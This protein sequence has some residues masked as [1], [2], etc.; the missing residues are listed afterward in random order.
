MARSTPT[1]L[2][3][4]EYARHRKARGLP[5]GSREA[6][7]KAVDEGRISTINGLIDP[8]V[9]DIQWEQNTR[10]RVS[11]QAVAT[12]PTPAPTAAPGADLVAQA[13]ADPQAAAAPAAAAADKPAPADNGYTALRARREK[14]DAEIA[15]MNSAKM[16]GA[17]VLRED[18]DRAIFEIGRELRDRLA[19]CARRVA[20]EVSSLATAE[21]CEEVIDREHR[22]VLELLVTSFREKVGAPPRGA[23]A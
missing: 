12:T 6:V 13:A 10:A 16:A 15:E 23:A 7:R 9:A 1:L 14:A 18:V 22:I 3:Q 20:A 11:P 21:A 19:S 4:A 5:G 2:T 17:L 8:A